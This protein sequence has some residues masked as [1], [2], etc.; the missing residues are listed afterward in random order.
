MEARVDAVERGEMRL[1]EAAEIF[2]EMRT[3]LRPCK[4]EALQKEPDEAF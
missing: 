1:H 2:G 3:R 4:N